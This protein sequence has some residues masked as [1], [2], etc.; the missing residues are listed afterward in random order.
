M[1]TADKNTLQ[2]IPNGTLVQELFENYKPSKK[3]LS[4]VR[5]MY[6]KLP[7]GYTGIHIRFKDGVKIDNCDEPVIKSVYEDVFNNAH[8]PKDGH[9]LIGNG[10][11]AAAQCFNHHGNGNYIGTVSTINNIIDSDE[12]LTDTLNGI[13]MEKG[14]LY[15]MLDQILIGMAEQIALAGISASTFQTQ[16]QNWHRRRHTIIGS[17]TSNGKQ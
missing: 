14:T 8:M 15:L 5:Q 12:A 16:I 3:L 17:V 2:Q 6:S 11:P 1:A 13:K 7:A 4:L 9:V 10:N